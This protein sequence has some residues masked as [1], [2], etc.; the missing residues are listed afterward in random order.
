MSVFG[1]PELQVCM[2]AQS[3]SNKWKLCNI[4]R[5]LPP[6][7]IFRPGWWPR[8]RILCRVNNTW[9]R[10]IC[11]PWKRTATEHDAGEPAEDGGFAVDAAVY[12]GQQKRCRT[13]HPDL[14]LGFLSAQ[15]FQH[16]QLLLK[17][18]ARVERYQ[19]P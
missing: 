10:R 14:V 8:I 11:F 19:Q 12:L 9:S 18:E 2:L 16:R 1:L 15:R 3:Q 6:L 5:G 7:K 4:E 17:L 13:S